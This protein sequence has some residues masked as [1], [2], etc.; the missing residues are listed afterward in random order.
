MF[1]NYLKVAVRSLKRHRFFTIIN[2]VGLAIGM[3]ISLLFIA[4]LSYIYR[5]DVFHENKN[6]IYRV[7]TWLDNGSDR[8]NFASAPTHVAENLEELSTVGEVGCFI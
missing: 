8:R 2:A 5:Y 1:Q 6:K 7:I 3:S 4:M